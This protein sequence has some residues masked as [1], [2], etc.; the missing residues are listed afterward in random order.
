MPVA[1]SQPHGYITART[2]RTRS[3]LESRGDWLLYNPIDV[4]VKTSRQGNEILPRNSGQ[5]TEQNME[6]PFRHN[7]SLFIRTIFHIQ[8]S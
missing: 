3:F 2:G 5:K 6:Q 7:Y 4:F 8:E 1:T